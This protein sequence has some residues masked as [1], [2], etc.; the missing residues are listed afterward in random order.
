MRCC[1]ESKGHSYSSH[2]VGLAAAQPQNSRILGALSHY[3]YP[4]TC[5]G[6]H[7]FHLFLVQM[8]IQGCTLTVSLCI[9]LMNP[10]GAEKIYALV[11]ASG[12]CI[13]C[14]VLPVWFHLR[15]M[16]V[17]RTAAKNQVG[18]EVR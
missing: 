5:C 17:R 6:V 16:H 13:V 1:W 18:L 3:H 11:G 9:A 2:C 10:G 4:L 7:L 15:L 14:Y 12:V 8:A